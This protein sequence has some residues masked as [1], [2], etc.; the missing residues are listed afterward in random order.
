MFDL[1]WNEASLD[2]RFDT[3]TRME[4]LGADSIARAMHAPLHHGAESRKS[5]VEG[6]R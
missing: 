6:T 4:K 2:N 1:I 5:A 3:R